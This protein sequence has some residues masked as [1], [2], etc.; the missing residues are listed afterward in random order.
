MVELGDLITLSDDK[1]YL[2]CSV[3]NYDGKDYLSLTNIDNMEDIIFC[4]Y[5][6]NE[7]LKIEDESLVKNLLMMRG[8]V[9]E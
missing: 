8:E 2:V 6:N 7:L 5:T 3:I 4:V 9:N 1:R